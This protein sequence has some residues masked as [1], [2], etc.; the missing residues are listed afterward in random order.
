MISPIGQEF[1]EH[2]EKILK[3]FHDNGINK[4]TILYQGAPEQLER[5]SDNDLK[6][7]QES[8]FY[9]LT[10]WNYRDS[11]IFID[12]STGT[13]TLAVV[14]MDLD[15]SIWSGPPISIETIKA[16]TGVDNVVFNSQIQN[17][18]EID[19]ST[20]YTIE[21]PKTD[22]DQV[23]NINYTALYKAF[24][25][26]NR[27]KSPM[28]IEWL[29]KA[30]Q[31]TS[32]ALVRTIKTIKAEGVF[33][34]DG[35][36]NIN[37]MDVSSIFE[38]NGCRLGCPDTSFFTICGAGKNA[39]YLHY[40][41]KNGK[42]HDGDLILLDC[43]I[44]YNHYSGDVTRTF[45]ANG[46]FTPI[47]REIYSY[48]LE[49]QVHL[50]SLVKPGVTKDFLNKELY[51]GIFKI[52]QKCG[53]LSQEEQFSKP[54]S[55][56]FI[57]H[58]LSHGVGVNVHCLS[59]FKGCPQIRDD[60]NYVLEPGMVITIEPGI[61]FNSNYLDFIKTN[62]KYKSINFE[63]AYQLANEVGGIRIEDD[64]LVTEQ[65]F[66]VLSTAPKYPDELEALFA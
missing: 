38:Y 60:W 64:V 55:S 9:W 52:A 45:P 63:R 23:D 13:S 62:E 5:Y 16:N 30:S 50:I 24:C 44:F 47:Q 11:T 26:A 39:A 4:G 8:V 36:L 32:E 51:E 56:I 34:S 10:G 1:K 20:I 14:D 15:Y 33:D 7:V 3:I 18:V 12:I 35:I 37:E 42:I 54:I 41:I 40:R 6:F 31:I 17:E 2:R 19:K 29:R 48:L 25:I 57:P 27:V 66:E 21:Q 59:K 22:E 46:K 53:I 61:Y 43:G 49:E 28:E 65:G 58:S